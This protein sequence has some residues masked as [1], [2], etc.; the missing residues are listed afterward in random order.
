VNPSD[1]AFVRRPALELMLVLALIWGGLLALSTVPAGT[2]ALGFELATTDL[3]RFWQTPELTAE[4]AV[5]A[6]AGDSPPHFLSSGAA[7][8]AAPPIDEAPQRLLI[9]GDSMIDGLLPPLADYA[10]ENGH[11]VN[12]VIWYGSRTIDWARGTRLADALRD[13]RPSF[14]IFVVGSSELTTRDVEKRATAVRTMLK[15]VGDRKWIWVGPPNWRKD[16]GLGALLER[17]VGAGR[18]FRSLELSFERK[19][20]GIHP[21]LGS[22]RR[23]MDAVAEWI[24]LKSSAPIRLA[25]PKK[26]GTPRPQARVFTPPSP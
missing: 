8:E 2:R 1:E 14:V 19:R 10:A 12:A 13:Y 26:T 4:P 11:S 25:P 5:R 20:D 23:W 9:L 3:S 24:Q 17:E 18:Y 21:T 22:S 6:S 7:P 15:L 16:T